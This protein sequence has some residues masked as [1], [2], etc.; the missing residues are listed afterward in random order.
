VRR[1]INKLKAVVS[2]VSTSHTT[3]GMLTTMGK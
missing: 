3:S 2:G 1:F